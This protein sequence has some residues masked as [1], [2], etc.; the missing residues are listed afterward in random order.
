M[1][2]QGVGTVKCVAAISLFASNYISQESGGD[3]TVFWMTE[4]FSS[5]AFGDKSNVLIFIPVP[6]YQVRVPTHEPRV[7]GVWAALLFESRGLADFLRM[8][9]AAK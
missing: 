8:W 3:I 9:S 1:C 2:Q 5:K 4:L 7:S 6:C